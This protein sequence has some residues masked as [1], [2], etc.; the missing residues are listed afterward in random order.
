MLILTDKELAIVQEILKRHIPKHTVWAF[1]SRVKGTT[2]K[3]A[4]LDLAI[5]SEKSLPLTQY[6]E[7]T[8]AFDESSLPF[9][10][11]IVDWAEAGPEFRQIIAQNKVIIQ[12]K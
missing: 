6:S 3:T 9:K 12:G 8:D 1:G 7:L 4:D 2:K 5:I 11:D 10:I